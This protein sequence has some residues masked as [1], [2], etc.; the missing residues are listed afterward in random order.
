MPM[1]DEKTQRRVDAMRFKQCEMCRRWF[2]VRG[3]SGS[4]VTTLKKHMATH[5]DERR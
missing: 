1:F 4:K 5:A 2:L 3:A